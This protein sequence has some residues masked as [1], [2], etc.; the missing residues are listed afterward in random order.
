MVEL[1]TPREIGL[2]RDSGRL[3]AQALAAVRDRAEVGVTLVELDRLAAALIERAGARPAFSG[4]NPSWARYP[5]PGVICASVN[6]AVVHGIP[7]RTRL[8][9]G[10]LVSI[11]CGA[12]L[13]AWC[14][15]AAVSFVVGAAEPE[16]VELVAAT[17]EALER[18]IAA[19]QPGN[20]LGDIG[21]AIGSVARDQGY[22][23]LSHHGG[24]G[25]GRAMHEEPFVPNEGTPG[26]GRRLLP[27]LVVA[28]EPM[29]ISDG[30]DGYRMDQNGWTVRTA[31][32]ARAAHAEHTVA[33]TDEGPVILTAL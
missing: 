29:L 1:K 17:E 3:V 14:G 30:N 26:R 7:D 5:F 28:I 32:G 20:H 8:A 11:D 9:E 15:D 18:G 33:I 19:A 10:D 6:D 13:G 21:H 12:F 25:V 22:A 23:L 31:D 24:H 16:D 4:Y 2:M 27:G